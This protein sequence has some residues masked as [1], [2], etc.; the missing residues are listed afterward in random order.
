M[1]LKHQA[2]SIAAYEAR[3]PPLF[4]ILA[5]NSP[6]A[7]PA[8]PPIT[9]LM[10]LLMKQLFMKSSWTIRMGCAAWGEG[11]GPGSECNDSAV[12]NRMHHIS[13]S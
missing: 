13:E 5:V 12:H 9:Q 4:S 3:T 6:N 2:K 11:N 1:E 10:P 8:R 7:P